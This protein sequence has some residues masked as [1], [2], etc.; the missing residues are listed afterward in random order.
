MCVVAV[1]CGPAHAGTPTRI[2][3]VDT[4]NTGRSV[5]AEALAIALIH[6][7]TLNIQVISRAFDLNPYNV[8]PEANAAILLKQHG[9]DV[10]SHRAVQLT[11]QDVRHSD[12]ILT[13]TEK[14]KLGVI[15][16]FPEAAGKTFTMSEYA[17]GTMHDVVDAYGQPMAVYE[18]VYAEISH[19][20]PS[21]LEKAARK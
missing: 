14:H 5:T 18:Q 9:I 2:A 6:E 1:L 20:L 8:E 3:F 19:Y 16:Q 21:V 7:K 10:S 12:L 4:G 17:T 13:A 15:A 11:I